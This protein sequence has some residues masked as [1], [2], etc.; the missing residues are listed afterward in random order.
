M[1]GFWKN[2]LLFAVSFYDFCSSHLLE[3]EHWDGLKFDLSLYG[4]FLI[5][6][7][8]IWNASQ[9]KGGEGLDCK[10]GT[11]TCWIN[12]KKV[13]SP[14]RFINKH[15]CQ[16]FIIRSA[17]WFVISSFSFSPSPGLKKFDLK[18]KTLQGWH[19]AALLH[20]LQKAQGF[21]RTDPFYRK[22]MMQNPIFLHHIPQR[23]LCCNHRVSHTQNDGFRP[24][25]HRPCP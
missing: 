5:K 9:K 12:L 8:S 25:G 10:V 15:G 16:Y 2:S 1:S 20:L 23:I 13:I 6:N 4:H 14:S 11:K 17:F 3:Q 18:N 22:M 19:L 24:V 7:C 21:P